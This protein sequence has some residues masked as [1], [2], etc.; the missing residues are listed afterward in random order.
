MLHKERGYAML[1]Q[2]SETFKDL[3]KVERPARMAGRCM[4]LLLVSK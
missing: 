4:T 3:A 2:I 1:E